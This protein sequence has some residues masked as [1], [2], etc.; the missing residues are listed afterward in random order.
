MT[1]KAGDERAHQFSSSARSSSRV[2][3][4]A[5]SHL[6]DSA[7]LLDLEVGDA[8]PV[9]DVVEVDA[10]AGLTFRGSEVSSPAS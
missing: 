1:W 6:A 10:V 5:A 4:D 8:A 2:A 9:G 7:R 3:G